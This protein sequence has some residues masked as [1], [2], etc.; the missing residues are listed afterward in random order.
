MTEQ[1]I[2]SI[3]YKVPYERSFGMTR[4][5]EIF[6]ML[7]RVNAMMRM[8]PKPRECPP[9]D[10]NVLPPPPPPHEHGR[11]RMMGLL[12]DEGEMIQAKLA[13]RLGIR[14]QSLTEVI[15]KAEAD[16]LVSRRQS[17]EDKR[18]TI[19]LLTE[20]G[21]SRVSEFREAHR[22]HAD[23]FLALLSCEEKDNLY[24]ILT[25]L[26]EQNNE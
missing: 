13:S 22:Q 6:M 23:E 20:E 16:G 18:Q 2:Y 26:T 11:G 12:A 9:H 7:R 14:P 3:I 4:E 10:P 21:M 25:K 8:H 15:A 5:E 17:E 1:C 24:A 19:V